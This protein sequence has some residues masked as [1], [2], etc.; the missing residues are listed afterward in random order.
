MI[1]VRSGD[2]LNDADLQ[3]LAAFVTAAAGEHGRG[4]RGRGRGRSGAD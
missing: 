4:G 1:V 3:A 2:R